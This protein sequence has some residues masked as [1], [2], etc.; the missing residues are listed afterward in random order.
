[1]WRNSAVSAL[2]P[3]N[4]VW[5]L[6]LQRSQE[7]T[8]VVKTKLIV[9]QRAKLSIITN[10][11]APIMDGGANI[12]LKKHNKRWRWGCRKSGWDSCC[13]II[14]RELLSCRLFFFFFPRDADTLRSFQTAIDLRSIKMITLDPGLHPLHC[15]TNGWKIV[16]SERPGAGGG[17]KWR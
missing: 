10:N 7:N 14:R 8:F 3:Y 12:S 11:G 5:R 13:P 6:A 9:T 2:A 15:L 4:N 17:D 1:M 16:P